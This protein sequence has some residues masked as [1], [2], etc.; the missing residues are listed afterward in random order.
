MT[1]RTG[2]CPNIG[3]CDNAKIGRQFVIPRDRDFKCPN[4]NSKLKELG[5]G[6]SAFPASVRIILS[7]LVL[8]SVLLILYFTLKNRWAKQI[9]NNA[10]TPTPVASVT[11][12]PD[13]GVGC[14]GMPVH[15]NV[16]ADIQKRGY[17]VMGVQASAPPMNDSPDR[18]KWDEEKGDAE[19]TERRQKELLWKRVGFD[20]E[21]AKMI[22]AEMGLIHKGGVKAREV[23]EFQ[24]LFCLLNR[25]ED[26]GSF[27]VDMVMSGIARDP[28]YDDTISW[29]KSYAEFGYALVTK[30]SSYIETLADCKNRKIG[31]V[32][33]D[34]VVKEYVTQNLIEPE[35]I[36]LSDESDEW[37]SDALNLNQ[38]DAVVYDYPFAVEEV[39]GI[40][41]QVKEHGV[42]G[43][44]LEIRIA[45]L[46][47]SELKYSIG[48]PK[49]EEDFLAMLN[50]AIDKITREE[51]P[52]YAALIQKYFSSRDVKRVEI[53]PGATVY[54]VQR[55]DSLA[56]IAARTLGDERRWRELGA[57][58][59]IGNDH[60]IVPNQKLILPK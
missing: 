31:I 40:N 29:S 16:W 42:T 11:P 54:I 2:V 14:K 51:N 3:S 35:I 36:E 39:K 46:P 44:L 50:D 38:V 6:T 37:L 48:V 27:S 58:N 41:E 26:D 17:L 20:Y 57:L 9:N 43:K 1:S 12:T 60:L 5:K 10:A 56:R 22:A 15:K 45:S 18:D 47:N 49:G 24:D 52:R 34:N 8:A 23:S 13:G 59:N 21:M 53:K 30:K 32:K 25:Q 33:G 19:E 4:C 55:G 28:N 7:L